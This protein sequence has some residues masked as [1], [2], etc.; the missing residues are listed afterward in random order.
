MYRVCVGLF[1]EKDHTLVATALSDENG[2]VEI[3][4]IKSGNYRLGAV[5]P[6]FG[7]LNAKL[8]IAHRGSAKRLLLHMEVK[9]IDSTSY[10]TLQ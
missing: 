6:G 5:S 10:A 3:N 2:H 4:Q 8:K 9:G 1:T 7:V